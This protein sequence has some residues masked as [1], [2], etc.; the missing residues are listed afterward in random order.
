MENYRYDLDEFCGYLNREGVEYMIIGGLLLTIIVFK[1]QQA[2]LIWYNPVEVNFVKL[3]LTIQAFG[4]ETEEIEKV[5]HY[6]VKGLIR[7]PLE[8][9]SIEWFL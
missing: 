2:T 1:G 8:R 9:Y 3:M 6:K 5:K 7:L 4:F